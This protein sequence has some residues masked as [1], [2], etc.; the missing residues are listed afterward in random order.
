LLD[1]RYVEDAGPYSRVRLI[2]AAVTGQLTRTT[3]YTRELVRSLVIEVHDGPLR[4]ARDGETF[5]GSRSF[6]VEKSRTPL[7]TYVMRPV[8]GA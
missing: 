5:D 6:T 2:A 8:E 4:L 1:V 3:T 7:S